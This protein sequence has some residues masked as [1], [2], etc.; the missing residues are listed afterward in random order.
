MKQHSLENNNGKWPERVKTLVAP[1]THAIL[2]DGNGCFMP[3]PEL[4]TEEELILFLRIAKV[5][6]ATDYHNVIENL[7]RMHGLPRIH[8]CGKPLYPIEA[9]RKWIESKTITEK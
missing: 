2:P 5:S 9:I 3:C 7:K 1:T 8:I 6:K 4:L